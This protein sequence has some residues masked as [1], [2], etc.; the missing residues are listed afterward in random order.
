MV[1]AILCWLAGLATGLAYELPAD[2]VAETIK[3]CI[4]TMWW[5]YLVY[6]TDKGVQMWLA[7]RGINVP[8]EPP[9]SQP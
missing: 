5:L 3:L 6:A 9:R 4:E 8:T 7:S 2:K 1:I